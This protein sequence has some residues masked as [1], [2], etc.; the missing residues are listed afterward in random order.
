MEDL[1]RSDM[2]LCVSMHAPKS[3]PHF[4]NLWKDAPLVLSAEYEEYER[5]LIYFENK[6]S[7][8]AR[9]LRKFSKQS[10]RYFFKLYRC[11]KGL[12]HEGI[13]LNMLGSG[14]LLPLLLQSGLELIS[15]GRNKL[16]QQG[17]ALFILGGFIDLK[18]SS[19]L[20]SEKFYCLVLNLL[21]KILV[22]GM[23]FSKKAEQR[24]RELYYLTYSKKLVYSYFS[25]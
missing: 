6:Q 15:L 9:F 22:E 8:E 12:L 5:A 20:S 3:N 16:G 7:E 4:I 10:P 1:K 13:S 2:M 19:Y 18:I 14:P 11:V 24:T 25:D 23:K 17:Q 21:K